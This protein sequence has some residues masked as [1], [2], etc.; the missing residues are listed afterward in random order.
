MQELSASIIQIAKLVS[1]NIS[2][3]A[4][5]YLIRKCFATNARNDK[6]IQRI[7]H[8]MKHNKYCEGVFIIEHTSTNNMF[9]RVH[10]YSN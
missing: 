7:E 6:L 4:E 5:F 3:S 9:A 8:M 2:Y 1:V 10:K